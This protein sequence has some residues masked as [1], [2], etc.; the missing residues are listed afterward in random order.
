MSA[1]TRLVRALEGMARSAGCHVRVAA[2]SEHPWTSATFIG[3]RH[4]LLLEAAP[5][6]ALAQWL[7]GLVDAEVAVPGHLV[8]D[9]AVEPVPGGA[10]VRALTLLAA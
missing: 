9:L 7:A 5:S 3:A 10:R 6:P 4:A 1:G 2:A 8:A